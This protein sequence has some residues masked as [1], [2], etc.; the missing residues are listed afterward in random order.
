MSEDVMAS[1]VAVRKL[2]AKVNLKIMFA[3]Y[4]E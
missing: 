4:M 3:Q 2:G 1:I